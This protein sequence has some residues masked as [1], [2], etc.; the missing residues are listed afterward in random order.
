[1]YLSNESPTLVD[2]YFACVP[3][4]RQRHND[5]TMT[6][7]PNNVIQYNACPTEDKRRR[8]YY[9][10]VPI[11]SGMQTANSWTRDTATKNNFLGNGGT[12]LNTTSQL[13]D[14][15]YRNYD[16]ALGR[17]NGVDPMANKYSSL[18]PYN[19]SFNNPVMFNDPSGAD[20]PQTINYSAQTSHW[21]TFYTYDDRI[22]ET[23]LRVGSAVCGQCWRTGNAEA[24]AFYA[25]ATGAREFGMSMSFGALSYSGQG[26]A[27]AAQMRSDRDG[28]TTAAYAQKYGTIFLPEYTYKVYEFKDFDSNPFDIRLTGFVAVQG[29]QYNGGGSGD[30]VNDLI[31]RYEQNQAKGLA[32]IGAGYTLL[33]S[34]VGGE[35][36]AKTRRA[37]MMYVNPDKRSQVNNALDAVKSVTKTIKGLI[38]PEST[39][40]SELY[41][42]V[43]GGSFVL[44]GSA[45]LE[46][47]RNVLSPQILRLNPNYYNSN[48]E[49]IFRN[50][51]GGGGASGDYKK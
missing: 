15:E 1:M 25:G 22:D 47:N 2:I 29:L 44:G 18:T 7:T 39:K 33:E 27:H 11:A 24:M 19:Y 48:I 34:G 5:V 42:S 3:K 17:M 8:K 21:F 43:I 32:M 35:L 30:D 41:I 20:P 38:G 6:L 10:F 37:T 9:P 23:E 46:Y 36:L 45:L 28:L 14:L 40:T 16:P 4:V 13:Y 31:R 49:R 51:F 50:Q 26:R 12:E